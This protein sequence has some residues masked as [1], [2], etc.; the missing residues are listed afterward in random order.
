MDPF[1]HPSWRSLLLPRVLRSP[2]S[3]TVSRH[4]RRRVQTRIVHLLLAR[5]PD[6]PPRLR[7]KLPMLAAKIETILFQCA[8]TRDDFMNPSTLMFRVAQ[9][10]TIRCKE[11]LHLSTP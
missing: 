4:D 5:R 3:N 1:R 11:K 7:R 10:H 2:P 6:A 8:T 9:V